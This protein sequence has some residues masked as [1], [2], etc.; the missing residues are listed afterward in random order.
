MKPLALI[1]VIVLYIFIQHIPIVTTYIPPAHKFTNLHF[2]FQHTNNG[3][4]PPA[5]EV[6]HLTFPTAFNDTPR[7]FGRVYVRRHL[8]QG[9]PRK[10]SYL[11]R[12]NTIRSISFS[13]HKLKPGKHTWLDRYKGYGFRR[14]N[15]ENTLKCK[16]STSELIDLATSAQQWNIINYVL[17]VSVSYF[18]ISAW[19]CIGDTSVR[20]QEKQRIRNKK[21]RWWELTASDLDCIIQ[22]IPRINLRYK[23]EVTISSPNK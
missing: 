7:P 9:W 3:K 6:A 4:I 17:W 2:F 22:W 8:K 23:W 1:Y 18:H 21:S 15:R 16:L 5:T 14:C 19:I 20:T 10:P 12:S 13:V 11:F